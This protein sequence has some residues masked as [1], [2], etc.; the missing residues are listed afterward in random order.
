MTS[1]LQLD[2]RSLPLF[3]TA[4][5]LPRG[6]ERTRFQL[7][8]HHRTLRG[9]EIS[10]T[11]PI[12]LPVAKIGPWTDSTGKAADSIGIRQSS[13]LSGVEPGEFQYILYSYATTTIQ[14]DATPRGITFTS[15]N[16]GALLG[17]Q[18]NSALKRSNQ[19]KINRVRE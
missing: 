7:T 9:C 1:Q 18:D 5:S 6:G 4:P 11:P 2:K 12:W 10:G 14:A 13:L 19:E 3:C 16:L 17:I 15:G 8:S